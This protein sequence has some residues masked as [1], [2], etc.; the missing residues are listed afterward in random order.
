MHIDLDYLIGKCDCGKIHELDVKTIII[1][2][3]AISKV[4]SFLVEEGI[5]QAPA[6]ICD[7]NTYKA[8][9]KDLHSLIESPNKHLIIL[10]NNKIYADE[11]SVKEVMDALD[12]KASSLIAV[13]AGTIHDVVRYV[14]KKRNLPF[15][16]VPTAASVDGFVSTVAAMTM[17]G[18]KITSQAVS[19]VG[20]FADTHI[21]TKAPYELT[22]A[23]V[24][25][26]LG[27]YTALLDWKVSNLLTKE[28]ICPKIVSMET[29]AVDQVVKATKGIGQASKEAYE[30]LMY[31]LILSGLAMQMIGNS[32]PASGAEHH[33]SHL[34]EMHVI[35]PE[36][37]ALHGE[38]VGVGL[39]LVCD[40]YKKLMKIKNIKDH[41]PK[42][43][44]FPHKE[45]KTTFKHLY[46]SIVEENMP[47]L[48]EEI[49]YNVLEEKF[50]E[51][52]DLVKDL[53]SGDQIREILSQVGGKT[54]LEDIG[55]SSNILEKSIRYSPFVRR[56][57]TLM[58]VLK[59]IEI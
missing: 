22:A 16:A 9:G 59:L 4:N 36:I 44:G 54:N 41:L 53:P 58:W 40:Q 18:F 3:G 43:K 26:L 29:E 1:E 34:W 21:F 15:I 30:N 45:L 11:K 27:K 24:G 51:I 28:Y 38:K 14:A 46:P 8:A 13:G 6:I 50:D 49:N 12:L 20:V 32:R 56:R 23:G 10:K 47:D 35:N 19:P 31:G 5:G 48:L 52:K 17:N 57:L 37:D 33:M 25:D 55:L 7:T 42:Y 2:E 39:G